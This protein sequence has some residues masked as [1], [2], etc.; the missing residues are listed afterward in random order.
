MTPEKA[1]FLSIPSAPASSLEES[2]HASE[3]RFRAAFDQSVTGMAITDLDGVVLRANEAFARIVGR[4][5]AEIVGRTSQHMTHPDDQE[6]SAHS[7]RQLRDELV[8]T[9]SFQKRYL[10][11]DGTAVWTRIDLALVRG[12]E[13]APNS[14]MATIEDVTEQRRTQAALEERE[15]RLR[16]IFESISD[17]AIV[18]M[19][20]AGVI[21]GWNPGAQAIFG[22]PAEE[23]IGQDSALLWTPEDRAEG[24]PDRERTI[25]LQTK[26]SVDERWLLRKG[27]ERFLASGVFRPI[28]TGTGELRG[29]SRICRDV[30]AQ[31]QSERDL[32]AARA[33]A[34]DALRAER[35][36]LV[37]VF[38][39]SP[40]FLSISRGP[41][42]VFEFANQRYH[43]ISN[44]RD[45]LQKTA[46]EAF[47]EIEGQGF[48]EILDRVYQ[49]G[50]P[51]EGKEMSVLLQ[52]APGLPPEKSFVDVVY[53]PIR[54]ATGAVTGIF[55]H[56]ID[57]TARKLAEQSLEQQARTF[58][59]LLSAIQDYVFIINPERRFTFA[60]KILLE[61]WGRPALPSD[62]LSMAELQYE[63]ELERQFTADIDYVFRTAKP[64]TSEV[65]Y[66]NPAGVSGHFEY[67]L[68]PV[69][70]PA[71]EVLS[72]AGTSR[73]ISERKR[74]ELE[75][76][77]AFATE[78]AARAEAERA[79]QMKDDFLATLS[80]E[81][82]T[83][84][85]AI[86][87][88]ANVLSTDATPEDYREGVQVIERNARAQARIIDDLLDMNR[89]M[90][91]KVRLD[92]QR[93]DLAGVVEAALETVRP[94]AAA[95]DVRLQSILDPQ[96]QSVSGD[97]NRLQQV[98]WNLL[99][100]AVKFTP[101]GG[102]VQVLLERVNSHLEVSIVDSGE[103]I[104][105]DFLPFVFDRFRQADPST[106]RFH[107][108]LGLGLAIVK[109]LVELHGGNVKAR[110]AGRGSGATFI[111]S[112]PLGV[113]RSPVEEPERRHPSAPQ[114]V[115]FEAVA[116]LDLEGVKV[117]IVDDEADARAVVARCLQN[118]GAAVRLAGSAAE[119]IE[120]LQAEIPDVLISDIGMPG[121][122]GYALIRRLRALP[123]AQGG[124]IPAIALTAYARTED[125][126]K[127]VLA[128]FQMHVAKPVEVAE[129]LAMVASL[130]GR[131]G[132]EN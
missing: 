72:V 68:A 108:G 7:V 132:Q 27:G 40:S 74:V 106:T 105:P 128:G 45:V 16:L 33:Q 39:L 71:G 130:S 122:D 51:F 77:E 127:A 64:I 101:K 58:D 50:E 76:E 124:G 30:T 10:R 123:P 80:H 22:Y 116:A 62:G 118:S 66:R 35:A 34:E 103:G 28:L 23:I 47:P 29:Y 114:A 84:L 4:P 99:S 93:T 19:D 24:L 65:G 119:A 59:I 102:R 53:M 36:R 121:E 54:D 12:T 86:L 46:R 79:S 104:A 1:S 73:N 75:R 5:L 57:I 9:A 2:L 115:P 69:L 15:E 43:E 91:G 107:G 26:R 18:T 125:R 42:H 3:E 14:L 113:V 49:T 38:Q 60:N 70:G 112:L 100:N 61:L 131:T 44:H 97:P 48:F 78:Q 92:V 63:P 85:N 81:L 96:A 52:K 31:R 25:A 11:P 17:Y 21:I 56:G 94:A 109:Q 98:F 20:P 95:K 32:A 89:I 111:V 82:R 87:G 6:N 8:R 55:T 110:S 13:G 126:M 90:S 88:W 67:I 129:L 120:L 117:L 41:E 83:P 37:E